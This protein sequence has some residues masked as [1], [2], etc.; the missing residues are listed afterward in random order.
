MRSRVIEDL[1]TR[2]PVWFFGCGHGN[3]NT[4]TGQNYNRIFWTCDCKEL[5]G[6][7]VYLLSCLTGRVLGPDIVAN[8][9]ATCYIGYT[10]VFGWIQDVIQYPLVDKYAK[11]FFEPILEVIYRLADG[12]TTR[13]SYLA[14]IDKWN[15]WVDYWTRS[16]DPNAPFVLQWLINDRNSQRLIGSGTAKVTAI[17]VWI[18]ASP[19]VALGGFT[20]AWF[21]PKPEEASK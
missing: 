11:G 6:R 4:F 12:R 7:V 18:L 9:K 8:K 5:A 13:E 21:L 20:V 14:S 1:G 2:D 3:E 16:T 19:L 15:Y 17:P 10:E